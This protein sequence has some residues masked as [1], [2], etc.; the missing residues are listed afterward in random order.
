[1]K[2]RF[3]STSISRASPEEYSPSPSTKATTIRSSPRKNARSSPCFR[4]K[5]SSPAARNWEEEDETGTL[6]AYDFEQLR[7]ATLQKDV[8]EIRLSADHRTLVYRSRDRMRAIDALSD[9]PESDDQDD[10]RDEGD[11]P[12]RRSGWLDLRRA[13]I[14]IEPRDEWAQ[15]Y[16]EAW[17][18]QRE[19]F[20]DESMSGIDWNLVRG[21]YAKLL[22]LVRTRTEL[23]DLMW[24][25]FGELGTSHAYE[26]GGDYR[27]PA[28]YRRGFLGA[29]LE[30][31][32]EVDGYRILKIYRGD[33]WNRDIDS[34]LA[35]PGLDVHEGDAVVAIGGRTATRAQSLDELLM[36]A[37]DREVQL[38]IVSGKKRRRI[39][40]RALRDERMLRYRAWVDGESPPRSR[41]HRRPRRVRAHPR[42]G[43]MGILRIPPR[44]S[45]RVQPRRVDRRCPL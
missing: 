23:S 11:Q 34:P 20:W 6:L 14:R 37:S 38:T 13:N 39:V 22:P 17:R 44:F 30:W 28:E 2:S 32:D 7:L 43:A 8:G 26:I 4:S 31:D 15:M 19:H 24:E 45:L 35:E 3:G 25:M 18:L 27:K 41:P 10:R 9:L 29:D 12:G 1:M 21:R 16:H 36:T 33:S 5:A 42:Y 40:V